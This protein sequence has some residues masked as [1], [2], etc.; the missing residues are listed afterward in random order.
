MSGRA[1]VSRR[2]ILGG[3]AGGGAAVLAGVA[4]VRGTLADSLAARRAPA[5]AQSKGKL[6]YW[7]GLIF[8]DQANN[9]QVKTINDWGK[10]NGYNVDVVM[11]N[12]NDTNQKVSAAVESGT[13]PD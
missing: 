9:L 13:M 3:L 4:G 7:G 12:Q 1:R 2:K 6:T 5:L 11:I 8:S 10:Q